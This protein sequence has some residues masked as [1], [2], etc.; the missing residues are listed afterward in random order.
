MTSE[1]IRVRG[2]NNTNFLREEVGYNGKLYFIAAPDFDTKIY[3]DGQ[4]AAVIWESDG[5]SEGTRILHD[6][7]PGEINF[8]PNHLRVANG[9][10]FFE[11]RVDEEG[12][13]RY[14]LWSYK[15][16]EDEN[17]VNLTRLVFS[18][19]GLFPDFRFDD[20]IE[21][22]QNGL[23]FLQKDE[24]G[25]NELWFTNG[26]SGSE[27]T[28][29]LGG[30]EPGK[31]LSSFVRLIGADNLL[32]FIADGKEAV[33][34][35]EEPVYDPN[36]LWSTTPTPGTFKKLSDFDFTQIGSFASPISGEVTIGD[37]LYFT[38]RTKLDA[39]YNYDIE[40]WVSHGTD[41]TTQQIAN[42]NPGWYTDNTPYGT[43]SGHFTSFKGEIYFLGVNNYGFNEDS[44]ETLY[45]YDPVSG[46]VREVAQTAEDWRNHSYRELFVFN[47]FLYFSGHTE[48]AGWELWRSDG[49]TQGTGLIKDISSIDN[50]DWK[51][52]DSHPQN[53]AIHKKDRT[54]YSAEDDDLYFYTENGRVWKLAGDS[55]LIEEIEVDNARW[56]GAG[57]ITPVD[58]DN[59]A[60]D[61]YFTSGLSIFKLS[62]S[63][64]EEPE[65]DPGPTP[66]PEPEPKPTPKTYVQPKTKN[67]IKGTN[68]NDNLKG[69]K[70]SD[71]INGKKGDDKLTGGKGKDVLIGAAG[72][73]LL[74]GS[75][76]KDYLDGSKGLDVLEGGKGA[77]VFQ[78]S[79]GKDV[80]HDFSINQGDRIALDKK[81]SYTITDDE[82]GIL[83][84][85]SAK[86]QLFLEGVDYDDFIEVGVD[87]FVQ[88][89]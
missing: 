23:F 69:T 83:I 80:V 35:R 56:S 74:I 1:L 82:D 26:N 59:G 30:N 20:N 52:W 5:T 62:D 79:K 41:Q 4:S 75:K 2:F 13:D 70:K 7:A 17:D 36:E 45:A 64:A 51:S 19:D 60:T 37:S 71:F 78:I 11:I 73:D 87:L 39:G 85:V 25:L 10:L 76:G 49:T 57:N 86:K 43:T 81:G 65:P 31:P 46:D 88:P 66:K 3:D 33:P 58:I 38:G 89:V 28:Y 8:V 68:K 42:L 84:L 48:E 12:S 55:G 44:S 34:G 47:E 77:D 21:A 29:S 9:H 72:K 63:Q 27:N 50:T 32:Y 6:F 54:L 14:E 18:L 22:T 40:P 67:E 24:D 61:L 15:T 16:I 53:F